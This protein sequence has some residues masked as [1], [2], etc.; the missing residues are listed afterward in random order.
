MSSGI[1]RVEIVSV[2]GA[3]ASVESAATSFVESTV[4]AVSVLPEVASEV[5][6][7][8]FASGVVL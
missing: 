1:D 7:S 8:V 6:E 3:I 4:L 2:V 5:A